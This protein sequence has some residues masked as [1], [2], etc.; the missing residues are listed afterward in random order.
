MRPDARHTNA[1]LMRAPALEAEGFTALKPPALDMRPSRA[2]RPI[3]AS[4]SREIER[5]VLYKG[6]RG[7]AAGF[8]GDAAL[9]GI[10]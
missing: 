2:L 1:Q 8:S 10:G 3:A 6:P 4:C 5:L 9:I 7:K